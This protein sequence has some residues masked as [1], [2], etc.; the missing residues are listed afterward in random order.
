MPSQSTVRSVSDLWL[1]LKQ[2]FEKWQWP[3]RGIYY[4][5]GSKKDNLIFT[6]YLSQRHVFIATQS[7][8]GQKFPC[9]AYWYVTLTFQPD[10]DWIYLCIVS[11]RKV[12]HIIRR[13]WIGSKCN[14]Q[15]RDG[16]ECFMN[17]NQVQCCHPNM[18][19]QYPT[20][21]L[22]SRMIS[23]AVSFESF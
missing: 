9:H 3:Q 20:E 22:L 19:H 18:F 13:W 1:R 5:W 2:G 15:S 8:D 7:L 16:L 11:Y 10:R 12:Q 6:F 21:W 23:L 14:C 4:L 17:L